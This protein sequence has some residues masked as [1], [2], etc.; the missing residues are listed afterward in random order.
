MQV[1]LYIENLSIHMQKGILSINFFLLL[2][3]GKIW[4]KFFLF[5]FGK[6]ED[7]PWRIRKNEGAGAWVFGEG[8]RECWIWRMCGWICWDFK[9]AFQDFPDNS[10]IWRF[11]LNLDFNEYFSDKD[12]HPNPHTAPPK[13]SSKIL[14]FSM[15]TFVL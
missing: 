8:S 5:F 9:A 4:G 12:L 7:F 2:L 3:N 10:I 11:N 15:Q 13:H 6:K 1:Y 14:I